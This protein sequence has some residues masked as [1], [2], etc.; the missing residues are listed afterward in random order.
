MLIVNT[1]KNYEE[2]SYCYILA[3]SSKESRE[4]SGSC[5]Q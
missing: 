3:A 5:M 1:L 2:L 4:A